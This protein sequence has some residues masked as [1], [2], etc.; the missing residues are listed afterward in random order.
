VAPTAP[1]RAAIASVATALDE[2]LDAIRAGA[3]AWDAAT[4]GAGAAGAPA[5]EGALDIE[6]ARGAAQELLRALGR[7]ELDDAALTRLVAALAGHPAAP[8]VAQLQAALGDFDFDLAVEHL[9]AVIAVLDPT[10]TTA[11]EGVK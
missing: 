8:R 2:A 11:Q 7:G 5:L 4:S 10:T 6:L 3:A 9:E 1:L